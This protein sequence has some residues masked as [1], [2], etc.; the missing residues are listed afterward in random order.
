MLFHYSTSPTS[1]LSII[2]ATTCAIEVS[3]M[4]QVLTELNCTCEIYTP[5]LEDLSYT[6]TDLKTHTKSKHLINILI[7]VLY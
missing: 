7:L 1:K 6:H 4:W 2:A 3:E 5:D